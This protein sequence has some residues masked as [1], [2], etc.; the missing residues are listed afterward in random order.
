[1]YNLYNEK[2]T[3][4]IWEIFSIVATREQPKYLI[5]MFCL[6]IP[7]YKLYKEKTFSNHPLTIIMDDNDQYFKNKVDFNVY[8]FSLCQVLD[9][10]GCM[11][12]NNVNMISWVQLYGV[13]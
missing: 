3:Q 13:A 5:Y 2:Q 8:N 1:L 11:T 6:S 10:N 4:N 7:C 12:I 9:F